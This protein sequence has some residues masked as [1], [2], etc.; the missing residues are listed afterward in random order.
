MV[1]SGSGS[2]MNLHPLADCPVDY[3]A[4]GQAN[5]GLLE[6]LFL[7]LLDQGY[8][9]ARRGFMALS[10]ALDDAGLAAFCMTLRAI[11]RERAELIR[12]NVL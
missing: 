8:Y 9:V 3:R 12:G 6:L 11:L 5:D 1:F 4:G 10:L 2:L 7:D